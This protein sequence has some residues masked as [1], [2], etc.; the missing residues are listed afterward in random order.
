[1][2]SPQIIV[3]GTDGYQFMIG[4]DAFAAQNTFAQIPDNKWIG[5]LEG[6]DVGHVIEVCFSHTQLRSDLPELTAITLAADDAGFRMLGDH[7]TGDIASMTDDSRVCG[8][9]HHIRCYGRNAGSQQASGFLIFYQTHAA[10]TVRF[11]I[12]MIA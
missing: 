6:F 2:K 3:D 12:R 5:L 8:L 9:N 4:S 1:V 7:Q 11:E 10:G